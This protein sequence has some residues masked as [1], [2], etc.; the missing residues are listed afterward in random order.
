MCV[1]FD[2]R[3][4]I[5]N[6]EYKWL[7]IKCILKFYGT[8][9]KPNRIIMK[10]I[11]LPFHS[12]YGTKFN[13]N[14]NDSNNSDNN[15]D[16]DSDTDSS[17]NNN[18]NNNIYGK[19]TRNQLKPILKDVKIKGKHNDT[20][21]YIN[22]YKWKRIKGGRIIISFHHLLSY[23]SILIFINIQ[24]KYYKICTKFSISFLKYLSVY[25][26]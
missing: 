11:D 4:Y 1:L 5:E 2:V 8:Y 13:N 18:N 24:N 7:F 20:N 17:S 21:L 14:N 9:M 3:N 6:Q 10:S 25:I 15:S 12:I 22:A 23:V 19:R 26:Y 16:L